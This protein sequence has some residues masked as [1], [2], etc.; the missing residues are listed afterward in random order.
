MTDLVATID[1]AKA[2]G[3]ADASLDSLAL[4]S[5]IAAMSYGLVLVEVN[6]HRPDPDALADVILRGLAAFMP[7]G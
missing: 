6:E 4:A 2:A 5:Y 1:K 3:I 7:Q